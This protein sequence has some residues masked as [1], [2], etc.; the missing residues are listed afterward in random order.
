[1]YKMKQVWIIAIENFRQWKNNP[2]IIM[3]FC[4][5]F[6]VCFL[7]S[8]K[9]ME[10]AKNS[11]MSLQILEPFIWT[12]GDATSVLLI[13]LCLLLLFGNMPDL[14]NQVPFLL[15][16]T[17]RMI[18]MFGQILYLVMATMIY[19]IFILLSTCMLSMENAFTTNMW[20]QAA[21]VLGY[22]DIGSNIFV[23]SFV[24]VMELSYPYTCTLHILGLM[25][26]YALFMV[27]LILFLNL[28]KRKGGIIGGI[29]FS[30]IGFLLTPD[31]IAAWFHISKERMA[32]ANIAFGWLSPLNHATYYMHNFGYDNLP[33]LWTSYLFFV[34]GSLIL[35]LLSLWK[36]RKYSFNFTG[37]QK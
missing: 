15:V 9:A 13:S 18:W 31:V 34:A 19:M 8:D 36:I 32:I 26:G 29:V 17:S 24:K 2:Q 28:W 21:A 11:D 30:G 27:S 20:S 4:L 25:I 22:S 23:P 14:N 35:F 7:L 1:M 6:I 16:R 10:F 12:F 37:T 33:K 3:T 5:G